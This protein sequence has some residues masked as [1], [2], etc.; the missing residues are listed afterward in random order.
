[1]MKKGVLIVHTGGGSVVTY[2]C[3]GDAA[4]T[5]EV[6]FMPVFDHPE[7]AGTTADRRCKIKNQAGQTVLIALGANDHGALTM[8]V[9]MPG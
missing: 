2:P 4:N 3:Y 1:M 7:V 6:W 9:P 8:L 5:A